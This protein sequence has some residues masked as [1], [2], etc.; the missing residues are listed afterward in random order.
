MLTYE[1]SITFTPHLTVTDLDLS[2]D[3]ETI[4]WAEANGSVNIYQGME[5]VYEI[6]FEG[7]VTGMAFHHE[8]LVVSDDAFGLRSY[9]LRANEVWSCEVPGGVSMFKI[10]N[11]FIAIVDNLGRLIISDLQG[12]L[13]NSNLPY[14]S[15]CK[16]ENYVQGITIVQE[17]GGV[18]CYNGNQNTWIR[19]KRGEVGESI[20]ALGFSHDGNLIIG[21]EGYALVPGDEEALELEIWDIS[22]NR[23]ITR[24]DLSNRLLKVESVNN[25]TVIGMDD[26]SVYL[27]EGQIG[28]GFELKE[29]IMEC[30]YPIKTLS[31]C[32]KSIVAGSWFYLHGLT[33]DGKTWTV[34]HQGIVQY[35]VY[36]NKTNCLY[37]AG[38]DQNDFTDSEPIGCLDFDKDLIKVDKSELTLWFEQKEVTTQLSA[39]Q[40]YSDDTKMT[41][42]MSLNSSIKNKDSNLKDEEFNNLLDALGDIIED[43]DYSEKASKND[44][45]LSDDSLLGEL[46]DDV[47]KNKP[48]VANAGNDMTYDSGDDDFAVILLDGTATTNQQ[49]KIIKWSWTD[50]TGREIST[51][52]KFRAKLS[53]GMYRFEL[54]VS[55]LEGNSTADSVQIEVV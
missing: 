50:D 1:A 30:K 51:L 55:D 25:Q 37:F 53:V 16:L 19:P 33:I 54:R 46:L 32:D 40:I 49:G 18:Y 26:G 5:K 28:E 13:I 11:N 20:T 4:A 22:T 15:I 38:D 24:L 3:G 21:R 27:I 31:L 12:N 48:L 41:E 17:D 23:L 43:S 42:L 35:S 44:S 10:T 7:L 45:A 9:D 14:S 47:I 52:T 2:P 36:S 39:D 29:P 6:K 8:H 34:E